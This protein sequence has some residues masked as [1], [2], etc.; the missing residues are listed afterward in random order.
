[1][2]IDASDLAAV[3]AA[4]E[5]LAPTLAAG[6]TDPDAAAAAVNVAEFNELAGVLAPDVSRSTWGDRWAAVVALTIAHATASADGAPTLYSNT[7]AMMS[8]AAGTRPR[9]SGVAY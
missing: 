8:A 5:R 4:F 6:L 2:A 3:R 1:M 9:W 7:L